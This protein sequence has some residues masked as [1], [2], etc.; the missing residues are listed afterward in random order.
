MFEDIKIQSHKGPYSACFNEDLVQMVMKIPMENSHFIVD[1][2]VANLYAD[3][4]SPILQSKK[5]ILIEANEKSKEIERII[6][7]FEQLIGNA[8][9]RDH[10]LFAIGGGVIQDITC[11]IASI[12][13]RGLDWVFVPTTLLAQTDS[14]IGSK[15]S[16][17]IKGVKN[18]LG[19]FNPPSKIYIF[20]QF[21]NTLTDREIDSGVG[22]ILKV[23]AIDSAESFDSLAEDYANLKSDRA[24]LNRY[25][26]RSLSIKK[27]YIEIDEFDRNIRNIFNYGHSFGHAIESATEY[28]IPHGIAVSLGMDMANHIAAS[29]GITPFIHYKRMHGVLRKNYNLY[30]CTSISHDKVMFALSQDKKNTSTKLSLIFPVGVSAQIQKVEV[31]ND[32]V[33]RKQC[34]EFLEGIK[35]E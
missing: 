24:T 27:K 32:E 18:I 20:P 16:I 19:T 28:L 26:H 33:F 9:R 7:I 23:H 3:V 17:N 13:L 11:F 4:L 15:S 6:P 2:R 30:S 21:L 5:V 10:T 31:L 25:I 29:R 8:A 12:F 34:I 1:S 22:E 35:D 14:C